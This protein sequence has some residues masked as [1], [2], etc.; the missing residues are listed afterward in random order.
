MNYNYVG[1]VDV[2]AIKDKLLEVGE[3]ICLEHTLRQ[4]QFNAHRETQT[5]ELNENIGH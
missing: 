2:S 4:T 5:V 1:N 3:E